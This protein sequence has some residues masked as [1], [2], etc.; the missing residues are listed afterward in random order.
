MSEGTFSHVVAHLKSL[1][2]LEIKDIQLYQNFYMITEDRAIIMKFSQNEIRKYNFT[3]DVENIY[4][5]FKYFFKD[6][7]C[8]CQ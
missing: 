2:N 3:S 1:E 5:E 8:L 7:Q 6:L 4:V